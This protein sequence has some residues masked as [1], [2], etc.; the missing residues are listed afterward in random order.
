[1]KI[2]FLENLKERKKKKVHEHI[3][4]LT[5]RLM[6]GT[7]ELDDIIAYF[8]KR[9]YRF[10]GKRHL[11]VPSYIY[12][13]VSMLFYNPEHGFIVT[14]WHNHPYEPRYSF[15]NVSFKYDKLP[16]SKARNFIKTLEEKEKVE[17]LKERE[18]V[19]GRSI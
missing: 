18:E 15:R 12:K 2:K 8:Q 14:M 16:I 3:N 6:S 9:K 10:I 11:Q 5:D 19:F 1:M 7:F 13:I 4:R 17:I